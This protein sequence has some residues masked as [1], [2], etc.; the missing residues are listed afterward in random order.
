MYDVG[1][2]KMSY[3]YKKHEK[4][5]EAEKSKEMDDSRFHNDTYIFISGK[6]Q[7]STKYVT[8]RFLQPI[9]W[10]LPTERETT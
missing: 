3:L 6:K 2:K 9:N 5:L 8:G 10:R 4:T 1:L 7:A